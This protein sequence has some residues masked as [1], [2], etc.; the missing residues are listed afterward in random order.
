VRVSISPQIFW[1]IK[2]QAQSAIVPSIDHGGSIG[3]DRAE[4]IFICVS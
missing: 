4:E 3:H 2:F 1:R